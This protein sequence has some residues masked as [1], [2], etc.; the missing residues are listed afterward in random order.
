MWYPELW[1]TSNQVESS[2]LDDKANSI[3]SEL[4][5]VY[6]VDRIVIQGL[7]LYFCQVINLSIYLPNI[8]W[9]LI[10]C[11]VQGKMAESFIS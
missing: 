5:L 8:Y 10:I 6:W 4:L 7:P 3:L 11:Q 9:I 2:L 1:Q